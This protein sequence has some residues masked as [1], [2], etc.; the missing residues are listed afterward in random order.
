MKIYVHVKLKAQ[1]E[2]VV[3]TEPDN[4]DISVHAAPEKGQANDAVIRLLAE[5]FKVAKSR[6]QIVAG[7]HSRGKIIEIL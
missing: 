4:F 1:R 7:H 6:V 5:H 2:S 3:E